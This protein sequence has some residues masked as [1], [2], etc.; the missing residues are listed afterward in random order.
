[1]DVNFT[2]EFISNESSNCEVEGYIGHVASH[3]NIDTAQKQNS[4][5]FGDYQSFIF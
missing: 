2:Y 1:M 3:K 5:F 4:L